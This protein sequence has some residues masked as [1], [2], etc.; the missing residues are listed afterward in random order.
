M[1]QEIERYWWVTE[2]LD[3]NGDIVNVDRSKDFPGF[4]K[5]GEDVALVRDVLNGN[6]SWAYIEKGTLPQYFY[7]AGDGKN[8]GRASAEV[9]IKFHNQIRAK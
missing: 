6:R 2:T 5:S 3:E 9:P 4:P 7:E 1:A 8:L